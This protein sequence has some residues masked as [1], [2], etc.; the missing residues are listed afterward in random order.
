MNIFCNEMCTKGPT[1]EDLEAKAR[2]KHSRSCSY[3]RQP[4]LISSFVGNPGKMKLGPEMLRQQREES[5]WMVIDCPSR[6]RVRVLS[7]C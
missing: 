5:K 4:S 7:L 2:I 6:V 3:V 1:V